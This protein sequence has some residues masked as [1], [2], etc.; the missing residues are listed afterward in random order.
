[1]VCDS[2]S[3][4]LCALSPH[5]TFCLLL[6]PQQLSVTQEDRGCVHFS[7]LVW[8]ALDRWPPGPAVR[9]GQVQLQPCNSPLE[10]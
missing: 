10:H 1:M 6:W 9:Q 4:M 3:T 8:L 5:G 7:G 2:P